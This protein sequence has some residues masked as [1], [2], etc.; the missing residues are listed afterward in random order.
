MT[1]PGTLLPLIL[2]RGLLP[3]Y[4]CC[5]P[6]SLLEFT[7][8]LLTMVWSETKHQVSRQFFFLILQAVSQLFPHFYDQLMTTFKIE[9]SVDR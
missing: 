8:N 7:H 2:M 3:V 6:F 1:D 4:C 5:H 9:A